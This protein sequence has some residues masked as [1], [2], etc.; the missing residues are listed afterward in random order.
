MR[1]RKEK[2]HAF[3][4]IEV[5]LGLTIFAI[6]A[7]SLYNTFASGL[8]LERR[9]KTLGR[10][11][12]EATWS[13]NRMAEDLENMLPYNFA[14]SYPEKTAFSGDEKKTTFL[15]GSNE[16]LKVVSYYIQ[17]PETATIH[18]VIIGERTK[19]NK[20]ITVRKEEREAR[21]A[22]LVREE[23]SLTD[24]LQSVVQSQDE[25][26]EIMSSRIKEG[27]LSFQYAYKEG[28]ESTAEIEWKSTWKGKEIPAGVRI[29]MIFL[30]MDKSNKPVSF[31][32]T[33]FI[34]PGT[35]GREE[36][37]TQ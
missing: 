30:S 17:T 29:Q 5:L 21:V 35:W 20:A 1:R 34:P 31:E 4:L 2:C 25:D 36:E 11:Y 12:R 18:K 28:Q 24:Y 26:V 3:T 19:R 33:V 14:G 22:F 8:L 32:R 15:L 10:V 23:R 37:V 16:G 7:L 9:S 27:G 13:L 6:I